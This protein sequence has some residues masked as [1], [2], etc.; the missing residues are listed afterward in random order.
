MRRAELTHRQFL[1]GDVADGLG[2]IYGQDM[3]PRRNLA[4]GLL[5]AVL[6]S[7]IAVMV[8][9]RAGGSVDL[10]DSPTAELELD[11]LAGAD[12]YATSVRI[13]EQTFP[14][15]ADTAFLA[16]GQSFP[17]A[18]AAGPAAATLNGPILLTA[19]DQLPPSVVVELQ[20]LNPS[21]VYILGG[22]SAVSTA[23]EAQVRATAT[24]QVRRVAGNDRYATA[25]AVAEL[26]FPTADTVYIAAGSGFAD[27]LAAGAPGGVLR[28]PVLLTGNI[29]V[30]AATRA[31]VTRLG[32]PDVIVLGGPA[33]VSEAAMAELD[34]LTTGSVERVSGANRY[35]TSAA[36]SA[37]AF[38]T[39][40]TVFLANGTTF[41][42]ALERGTGRDVARGASAA[43][44]SDLRSCGDHRRGGPPWGES[45]CRP[46]RPER[47]QR[48]GRCSH[49][50][51]CR[52]SAGRGTLRYLREP[53]DEADRGSARRPLVRRGRLSLVTRRTVSRS[54]ITTY[55]EAI[56][57]KGFNLVLFSAPEPFYTDNTPAYRNE[58]G[59]LPF[60]DQLFQSPLN[61]AYWQVVDHA[62]DEAAR[63]GITGIVV[64]QYSGYA[65]GADGWSQ[66]VEAA[67]D[68]DP[69]NLID[70]GDA[71]ASRFASSQNIIWMLGHD[72]VPTPKFKAASRLI[73]SRLQAGTDHMVIQGG[74][75]DGG[76]NSTGDTD[77]NG[78]AGAD[79]TTD[80]DTVYVYDEDT[81]AA[82]AT[83][84]V[85]K[86]NIFLEG[87][88]EQEQAQGVGDQTLREQMWEAF[89]NGASASFLGNNPR[90]HFDSGREIYPYS[91][92][93]EQSLTNPTYNK[94]T[95]HAGHMADF[96]ASLTGVLDTVPDTSSTFVRAGTAFG[97][98]DPAL[99]VVYA[100]GTAPITL[101]TTEL[102]GTSNVRIRRFDPTNGSFTIVAASE[103]QSSSRVIDHPGANAA[104][105]ND[106]VYT[107]DIGP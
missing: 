3:K 10:P 12:R 75:N 21:V 65:D 16:T 2:W 1:V 33:V 35:A 101:D 45:S 69:Q 84:W 92:T 18:L 19:T 100:E 89:L 41:P 104:G 55:V 57:A 90:W 82:T 37:D 42:D 71:L 52:T 51:F 85:S 83:A 14:A 103:P 27:A 20:R 76:R 29:R 86:A 9:P 58:S 34:T 70:Y 95:V 78:V 39:A 56:A 32:N 22:P 54:D 25:G 96:I 77:W 99:G 59:D 50:V 23:V 60:T 66:A 36:V 61:D 106:Y 94:G 67:Y 74:W 30:P 38:A 63:L 46:G 73:A 68:A 87:K 11:R 62:I 31:Q 17:D 107:I 5:C 102:A 64:P 13:S 105:G 49:T 47:G 81:A 93:W 26:A 44:E 7:A 48:C 24:A 15:G 53:H 98:F 72:R 4:A 91:G 88:Y 8:L 40:S 43:H 79:I 6:A 80:F 28:R 97:R